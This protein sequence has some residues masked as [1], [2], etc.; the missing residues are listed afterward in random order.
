MRSSLPD[1]NIAGA[2]A[3]LALIF[4]FTF[5]KKVFMKMID[6]FYYY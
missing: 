2:G 3:M 5:F 6:D 1:S 4:V